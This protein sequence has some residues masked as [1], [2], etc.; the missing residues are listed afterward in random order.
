MRPRGDEE[1]QRHAFGPANQFHRLD[2]ERR[3]RSAEK[4]LDHRRS[5]GQFYRSV[6]LD[7]AT[8]S[9]L[10]PFPSTPLFKRLD[11]E[12]RI[13]TRDWS[14]YNGKKDVVFQPA[15]MAPRELLMGMEWAARQFYSIPSIIERLWRSRT[16]LWWNVVRNAGYHLALR[17]FGVVGFN[18]EHV[19]Q[20]AEFQ[21]TLD[22]RG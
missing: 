5:A 22:H 13:L 12:G 1:L 3:S 4:H 21:K 18:P 8:I 15:L 19:E 17:N 14:K 9:V 20:H 10:I 6:G 7:S 16:G 11:A 2:R